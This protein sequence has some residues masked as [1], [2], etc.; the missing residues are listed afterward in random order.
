MYSS[1]CCI[2]VNKYNLINGLCVE[3]ENIKTVTKYFLQKSKAQTI[4]VPGTSSKDGSVTSLNS[5]YGY[6]SLLT[7]TKPTWSIYFDSNLRRDD[8]ERNRGRAN[9]FGGKHL[10]NSNCK[11]FI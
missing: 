9:T 7:M 2:F 3:R 1:M 11:L 8:E 6:E 4:F 10:R 5:I